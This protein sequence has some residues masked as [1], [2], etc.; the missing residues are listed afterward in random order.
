MPIEVDHIFA[1][2]SLDTQLLAGGGHEHFDSATI[3]F[4]YSY[5]TGNGIFGQGTYLTPLSSSYAP[6]ETQDTSNILY[7]AKFYYDDSTPN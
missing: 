2:V 4:Q 1:E 5:A 7:Q 3:A 6:R